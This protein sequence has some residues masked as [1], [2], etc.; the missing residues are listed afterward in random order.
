MMRCKEGQQ[1]TGGDHETVGSGGA[2]Q[3]SF[4]LFTTAKFLF[5]NLISV[6]KKPV[7]VGDVEGH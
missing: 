3:L 4:N 5:E 6:G 2:V 1:Q 7:D